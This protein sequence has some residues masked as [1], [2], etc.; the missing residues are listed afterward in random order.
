MINKKINEKEGKE[1]SMNT[2]KEKAK[3]EIKSDGCCKRHSARG[4]FHNYSENRNGQE[5]I[6]LYE[7]VKEDMHS[8]CSETRSSR[9]KS[10]LNIIET[11]LSATHNLLL[12][13]TPE[14]RISTFEDYKKIRKAY[15][16]NKGD[17]EDINKNLEEK[18]NFTKKLIDE[19]DFK[20]SVNYLNTINTE[21]IDEPL[22]KK[23][24]TEIIS[25]LYKDSVTNVIKQM[26]VGTEKP[27]K[28]RIYS[29]IEI[30]KEIP[31][32]FLSEKVKT[33]VNSLESKIDSTIDDELT[34][35]DIMYKNIIRLEK[36]EV[37]KLK[38]EIDKNIYALEVERKKYI[39]EKEKKDTEIENL[40]VSFTGKGK[41]KILSALYQVLPNLDEYTKLNE[42][43]EKYNQKIQDLNI[44][45]E[46]CRKEI[47]MKNK[48]LNKKIKERTLTKNEYKTITKN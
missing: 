12:E 43:I 37:S 47:Y 7:I 31:E 20:L 35:I 9:T 34:P 44:H 46:T 25:G 33:K 38:G 29:A 8:Y 5:L 14:E 36:S 40:E 42:T 27:I 28:D 3:T 4:F 39:T 26:K 21:H 41:L 48:N 18:I 19:K 22:F 45:K 32:E 1:Y 15:V 17:V 30:L 13:S 16:E 23:Y 11:V 2:L 10:N 6:N 24:L